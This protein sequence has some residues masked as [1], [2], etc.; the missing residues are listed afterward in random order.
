MRTLRRHSLRKPPYYNYKRINR[1]TVTVHLIQLRNEYDYIIISKLAR[2]L[3][4]VQEF[5]TLPSLLLIGSKKKLRA[6]SRGRIHVTNFKIISSSKALQ[7]FCENSAPSSTKA[8]HEAPYEALK[9][10]YQKL[11]QRLCSTSAHPVY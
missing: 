7:K 2:T 11:Y 5:Q 3:Y 1:F 9:K 6:V 8:L 4:T 10:L